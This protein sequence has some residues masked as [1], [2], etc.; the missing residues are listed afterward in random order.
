MDRGLCRTDPE[1]L[2][3]GEIVPSQIVDNDGSRAAETNL[4][5]C[6]IRKERVPVQAHYYPILP[7]QMDSVI[8]SPHSV[9]GAISTATRNNE[10]AVCSFQYCSQC[11][12]RGGLCVG[13][14]RIHS[15]ISQ[16]EGMKLVWPRMEA[17]M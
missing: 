1:Q 12:R 17:V 10:F 2:C 15:G 9:A 5:V 4:H 8:G 11:D 16:R 7:E 3:P 13:I 14:P 6:D